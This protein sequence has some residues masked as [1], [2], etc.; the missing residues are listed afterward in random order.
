MNK[1]LFGTVIRHWFKLSYHWFRKHIF[2]S[3]ILDNLISSF[4]SRPASVSQWRA[5][6]RAVVSH[7]LNICQRDTRLYPY[8][9][10]FSLLYYYLSLS[11]PNSLSL[12]FPATLIPHPLPPPSMLP[13][14]PL[15]GQFP[16]V[17]TT[18][19]LIPPLDPSPAPHTGI[20]VIT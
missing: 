5:H 8:L 10:S 15:P 18:T 17:T 20:T 9:V 14:A 13:S 6:N 11:Q 2:W 12:F 16:S 19:S 4:S 1:C 3:K 7:T